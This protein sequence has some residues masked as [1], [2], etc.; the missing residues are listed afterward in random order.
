MSEGGSKWGLVIR[1]TGNNYLV[2][3]D[4]G[5]DIPCLAKGSFRLKGIR[6]TSP[7]VVGDKVRIG[8]NSEGTAY[9]TEIEDRK[10]YIVRRASN[11]S[12]QAHILAANIDLALL[13]I[14]VRFPETT[15]VFI[16]RFL[17]TAEAYSVPVHLVFNKTDIY[18]SDD[19]EYVEGLIHLYST[20]GYGSIKTSVLTG[21]GMDELREQVRGK[22]TLLAGHSGVGKSSIV[23]ALQKEAARKVGKISD[24]H[25]KGMHTTTFSEMIELN[26]G[27]FLIDTPGIKGFGTID[28]TTA[29]VSHYFPEIFKISAKCK[30]NNCLHLN[31]PGCAVIEAL[32]NRYIS[33]SRYHSYLNI[34][35]DVNEGKYR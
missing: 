9:I 25:N 6:S 32:E 7:V 5:D 15:T 3:T 22:I 35:E 2:R 4:D 18:D 8:T 29:E 14:T 12:K 27:G 13:C 26:G 11:L 30:F 21:K 16:D 17:V 28:M 10:N 19:Q 1:N 34:L 20:I 24:Y 23:N 33:Q 31:E